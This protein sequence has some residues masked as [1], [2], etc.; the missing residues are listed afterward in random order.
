MNIFSDDE[1][2]SD[3]DIT[4]VAG[5]VPPEESESDDDS[6][7]KPLINIKRRLEI[8]NEEEVNPKTW[9]KMAGSFIPLHFNS[10]E[11]ENGYQGKTTYCE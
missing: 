5:C 11:V 10:G 4:E 9:K 6:D 8:E 1:N 7:D 3:T 2:E